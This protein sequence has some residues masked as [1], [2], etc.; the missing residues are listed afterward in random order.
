MS[1]QTIYDALRTGGL[2]PS[3][4]CAMM[5][6]MW[7]ESAL[8]SNNVQD[9]CTLG[10][11]DYTNA[12]DSGTITR[13]QFMADGFGYGL[14]QWT[15]PGRKD[16]LYM[17]AR[18]AG[19]SISNEEMQVKFCLWELKNDGEFSGLYKYLCETDN[20]V[21]ASERICKE[22]EKPQ[23]KNFKPRNE[24]AKR[25]FAELASDGCNT[26]ACPIEV[27]TEPCSVAVRTLKRGDLGRDVFLLQ[28]GL[29]DMRYDCGVPDGDFGLIT[30]EA[31]NEFQRAYGLEPTGTADN[32]V[33]SIILKER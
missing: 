16:H 32:A 18:D 15:Y 2:S 28:C 1:E 26:D 4:A 5:G 3:G 13:W 30:E 8:K 33:W 23:V 25:Y 24:A 10:D 22:Y 12:V 31:V 7:C 14:C 29:M 27:P 21:E 11:F 9:N 20:V 6:N 17:F 19:V